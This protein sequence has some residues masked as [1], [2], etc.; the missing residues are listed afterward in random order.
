MSQS[1]ALLFIA[2]GSSGLCSTINY[3]GTLTNSTETVNWLTPTVPKTYDIDG[4]NVYGTYAGV[5]WT[6]YG[7]YSDSTISYVASGGQ[8]QQTE[9]PMINSLADACQGNSGPGA[10]LTKSDPVNVNASITLNGH[11]FSV[12]SDL[13][14]KTL[15]VGVMT[16]CLGNAEIP[17]DILR[18]LVLVQTTGG[19]A[20]S[21]I[22]PIPD[23]DHH[24]DMTFFDIVDAQAGDAYVLNCVRYTGSF[25][26]LTAYVGDFSWDIQDTTSVPATKPVIVASQPGAQV[27]AGGS[28]RLGVLA[29]GAPSLSYQ[30]YKGT[31]MISGATQAV[32]DLNTVK[33]SDAG[34]YT[35]VVT[36][37]AGSVTS[38][39]ATV[40]VIAT[41]LPTR[42]SGF[43]T[44]ALAMKGIY[45]YYSFDNLGADAVGHNDGTF[46][47]TPGFGVSIGSGC[48]RG[49]D[50]GL[51][52]NG[53]DGRVLAGPDQLFNFDNDN[54]EGTVCA[55]IRPAWNQALQNEY[56]LSLGTADSRRWALGVGSGLDNLRFN[57]T[58]DTVTAA[59]PTLDTNTWYLVSA[60]FFNGTYRLYLN[61]ALVGSGTKAMDVD[62]EEPLTI[63]A[64]DSMGDLAWSGGL[65]EIA[66]F[67]SALSDT[68]VASLYNAFLASDP[69][70]IVSE[71]DSG[72][73]Y[74]VG[75]PLSINL[76]AAGNLL[77]YQWYL[78]GVALPGATTNTIGFAALILTDAGS[79]VCVVSNV[80]GAVTST[81]CVVQ[82]GM[83][84]TVIQTY[85]SSVKSTE[86]LISLYSF[87]SF[88]AKDSM[89]LYDGT[90]T[91]AMS[92]RPGIAGGA[93]QAASLNGA[94]FMEL[95]NVPDF[96]F[97]SGTGTVELWVKS[98]TNTI[99]GSP[100]LFACRE[101]GTAGVNYS[102]HLDN[103]G[104]V[105][106]W[107]GS[108]ATTITLPSS[109]GTVWHH[110]AVIFD[111]GNW[112]VI[113]DGVNV[114]TGAQT[115]GGAYASTH[116]GSSNPGGT[117]LWNGL[118]DEVAFYSAALTPEQV[119]GHYH[120]V[121]SSMKPV[122][123]TQPS[124]QLVMSG[125]SFGLTASAMGNSMVYQWFKNGQAVANATEPTL[126]YTSATSAQDGLYYVIASNPNGSITSVV[127]NVTVIA[128]QPTRY[129]AAVRATPG[130]AGYYPFDDNTVN[131]KASSNNGTGLGEITFGAGVGG[132]E[133]LVLNGAGWVDFGSVPVYNGESGQ[134]TFEAW[135]RADWDPASPP[136][137]NPVIFANATTG[138]PVLLPVRMSAD[139][140]SLTSFGGAVNAIPDAGTNWHHVVVA[141]NNPMH[142]TFWDGQPLSDELVMGG[143]TSLN[144]GD[145]LLGSD[146]PAGAD[147]WVGSIDNVAFYS[148]Q[149][150]PAQVARHFY[151]MLPV[152]ISA[153]NQGA[154]IRITWPAALKGWALESAGA[155]TG[156]W[157]T[158]AT[159]A[160]A[161]VPMSQGSQYFR[162]R[163]L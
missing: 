87:D 62:S 122:W 15:R 126:S 68:D 65:D 111:W 156:P 2:A 98:N 52:C 123:V 23:A 112:T 149:L 150:S 60:V 9:Y 105:Y 21:V 10:A 18:A 99:S 16:D 24:P 57:T 30:W 118:V 81:P 58:A 95:G 136:S 35:V 104:N 141:L 138:N 84:P 159:N 50:K 147:Q 115:M 74:P 154:N 45:A 103:S 31:S 13:T 8:F 32:Y 132:G 70:Q 14:G 135:V 113:W 94:G 80:A 22:V 72:N 144:Y 7:N 109:V 56:F 19:T 59:V 76:V 143:V 26:P 107:N 140:K 51:A 44:A 163:K 101:D 66:I 128:P 134:M 48:G 102:I 106:F 47:G 6:S 137:A 129:E 151:S 110:M 153:T 43:R 114:G 5:L 93:D 29:G 46:A 120:V 69:P 40:S 1:M 73:V 161:I 33:A 142:Q 75:F 25:S 157:S 34:D 36:T 17:K 27:L 11:T 63:G 42:V 96:Y 139:K 91:G 160:P 49:I 20:T 108:S 79:Y 148:V 55:W 119:A 100:C 127:A 125:S 86:G 145:S 64:Y 61:G 133:S 155:I 121:Q 152:S 116:V 54:Q 83:L 124:S 88:N 28:Y 77:S 85:E 38:P 3:V 131:D 39:V 146:D 41:N 130:L 89:G 53:G 71:P 82:I 162:L 97:A 12:N 92:Y 4:D 90:M 78:D 117:E 37:A 67:T 158:T